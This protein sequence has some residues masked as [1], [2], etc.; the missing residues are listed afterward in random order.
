[1]NA[2]LHRG[3]TL[4]ELLVVIA[5]IGIL[6]ALLLPAVQ[7][8]REA[9]RRASCVNKLAQLG[10]A[11][12]QYESAHEVLPQGTI[13]PTGPIQSAPQG[14]H[15]SWIVQLLP[16]IEESVTHENVDFSV[17]VYHKKNDPVRAIPIALLMCPSYPGTA[18]LGGAYLSNYAGCHHDV[19]API[20]AD[21]HGV[22]FLN[23]H[24][25]ADDVTDGTTH[26]IYVGEKRGNRRDLGWMSGTRATLRNTGTPLNMTPGDEGA[27]PLDY[28][29]W[30]FEDDW[31]DDS[32]YSAWVRGEEDE[33]GAEGFELE[34]PFEGPKVVGEDPEIAE[35]AKQRDAAEKQKLELKVGGFGAAHRNVVNFL[36]G[37]GAVRGLNADINPA[38]LQQLGH[39][40]DGKLLEEGPTRGGW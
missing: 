16:Y 11:L 33:L 6:I 21:N 14:Q 26:T 1:M 31:G 4:V 27:V 20:D 39:R 29:E 18:N 2:R 3:F 5:I 36:F 13:N 8:A 9:A 23:S 12:H 24:I 25:S 37:D 22:L 30:S 7:S 28:S 38:V 17:G 19:E 15:V 35:I 32:D 34:D 40:A 10:V